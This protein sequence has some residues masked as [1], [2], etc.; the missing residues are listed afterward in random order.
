MKTSTFRQIAVQ[1]IALLNFPQ[2][3]ILLTEEE[4]FNRDRSLDHAMI[5]GNRDNAPSKIIFETIDQETCLVES[6]VLAA[7][8]SKTILKNGVMI[9][10][11]SIKEVICT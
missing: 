3:D 9:P 10:I 8:A 5:L 6:L 11:H 4:R 7:T 1:E 2:H